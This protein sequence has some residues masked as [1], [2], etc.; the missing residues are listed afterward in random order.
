MSIFWRFIFLFAFVVLC[1]PSTLFAQQTSGIGLSPSLIEEGADPGDVLKREMSVTNL[2]DSE[3]T[4]YLYTRDIATVMDGGRPVYAEEGAERTGYELSEWLGLSEVEIKLA[5]KQKKE[6]LVTITVPDNATPG[7]HFGAVFVSMQ[8]PRLREVGASVGYDVA[9]IISIRISG[10]VTESAQIRSFRTDKLIYGTTDVSFTAEI[11]N[12]G[13]VLIRPIGPLEVT[14]MFGKQ[15]ANIT[16]NENQGGVFPFTKREFKVSWKDD[17]IGF[18][19]YQVVLAMVYG[20]PGRQSTMS[21]TLSF[22]VLPMK[23]ITPA[24]IILAVLLLTTYFA[25]RMYI[26]RSVATMTGGRRLVRTRARRGGGMSSLV[27]VAIVMLCVT[28]LFLIILL[29]LF[30]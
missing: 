20:E 24:L 7:S 2:S 30:A 28:T 14:N 11:E 5:P 22:W 16:V 23:I 6:I 8:P 12:K 4:Y 18:G 25:V 17:G 15:V 13:N 21:S 1:T 26:R 19:R 10:D 27:L 9:N 3:Q 29:A